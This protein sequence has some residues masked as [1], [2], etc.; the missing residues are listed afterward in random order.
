MKS[1][2]DAKR[3]VRFYNTIRLPRELWDSASFGSADR[4]QIDWK[5]KA[6]SI[7]RVREGGVKPKTMTDTAVVLQ[8]WKLGNLNFDRL[9]V[10]S[11]DTSLRLASNERAPLS[12]QGM[13][14]QP[15]DPPARRVQGPLGLAVAPALSLPC[16]ARAQNLQASGR[17]G[18]ISGSPSQARTSITVGTEC[19]AR[20][21]GAG[22]P[23]AGN[24][25][26][27]STVHATE[28]WD[29]LR[30]L[31]ATIAPSEA[32]SSLPQAGWIRR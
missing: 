4:L 17:M 28:L 7:Q 14:I 11:Q 1:I 27:N 31:L 12:H 24:S 10:T 32:S 13:R 6:L 20:G 29:E 22:R 18:L 30:T 9:K 5:G 26:S 25:S 16:R 23:A 3:P 21:N 15:I 2:P 8:S 19:S